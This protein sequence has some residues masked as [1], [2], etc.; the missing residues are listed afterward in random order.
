MLFQ[1]QIKPK[2]LI[3]LAFRMVNP[4]SRSIFSID[5]CR[6]S[7]W[8]SPFLSRSIKVHIMSRV[9]VVEQVQVHL[10]VLSDTPM[11]IVVVLS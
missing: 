7:F 9:E 10:K 4:F 3:S 2:S 6:W 5:D 1:A 8:G 11:E